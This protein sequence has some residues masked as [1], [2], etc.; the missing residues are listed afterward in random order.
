MVYFIGNDLF[1]E[2]ESCTI[3]EAFDY[4]SNQEV[5]AIDIETSR[6]FKKGTYNETV[7]K[8]G[9]DPFMS[10]IIMFQ[11]GTLEKRFAIDTRCIDIG[12]LLPILSNPKILKV[13]A[14]LIFESLHFMQSY[15][16]EIKN[17]YDVLL[18]D[19][20]LTNGLY[21]SYSLESLMK[22]YRGYKNEGSADLFGD[23]SLESEIN[24]LFKKRKEQLFFLKGS[25]TEEDEEDLYQECVEEIKSTYVDKSIRLEFVEL[26][27]KPFRIEHITYGVTDI[28][29]PLKLREIFMQGR[30]I[31][32]ERYYP[33][34][35]IRQENKLIEVLCKMLHHGVCLDSQKWKEL[36]KTKLEK[37]YQI[38]DFLNDYIVSNHPE[39]CGPLDMFTNKP[40]SL[41]K[42]SSPKQIQELFDKLG[43]TVEA[44]S[45]FTGKIEKTVGAKDLVKSLTN[46]YKTKF[47]EDAIP[48]K[49]ESG[50][51]LVLTYLILK[52]YQML[53]TTYGE[54]FLHYVHPITKRIHCN[55]R[56]YLNTTRFAATRPNALAI[57]RGK[58]YREC[59]I[60]PEGYK[61]WACDYS[62]QEMA[63]MAEMFN[64]DT[65]RTFFVEKLT[66]P[67]IDLHSWT[68]TQVYKI[69]YNDP[70]FVC[71]KKVH[72]KERQASKTLSFGIPYGMGANTLASN[73][74]VSEE[75][76]TQFLVMYFASF[77]GLEESFAETKKL[78]VKRG[79]IQICKQTDKRYFF[80]NFKRMNDAKEVALS[81]Y[82]EDYRYYSPEKKAE[83]KK[84][85][86]ENNPEVKEYWRE[87]AIEKGIL[88]RRSVNFRIQG[89]SA[90]QSKMA[91][92]YFLQN[93][94][95][96]C[97]PILL[98]HD[99]C[100][101][102]VK[103]LPNKDEVERLTE[104][105]K[106]Q[107]INGAKYV[108]RETPMFAEMEYG[109]YWIH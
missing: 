91:L 40:S 23:N 47:M 65:L 15:K 38:V 79:W 24:K 85:L 60:A 30:D 28:E 20:I 87:F 33:E 83:F 88:E 104:W 5:V 69:M 34:I 105:A 75:E 56:Q 74:G 8:P 17:L 45:K 90:T 100:L 31:G 27:D 1:N 55:I 70:N 61:V 54:E 76:A 106:Q 64:N 80:R 36:A 12:P 21:D 99:E 66:N 52:K 41:I 77:P 102:Y 14:N 43:L 3:E 7:Y 29:E 57:P 11:I 98:V 68:A 97:F 51:D 96:D 72:K 37:Y 58:E 101:G 26:G 109:D 94:T 86:Y 49:I 9:L 35:A 48:E 46:E 84:E 10:R 19:R 95:E 32:G 53:T 2:F 82:P 67:N 50:Q 22:R 73:L 16:T 62:T 18:V 4:L 44:K 89:S 6:K 108:C 59:F 78:A 39:Y 63:V 13:G 81:F 42:W 107:M 92:L 25:V 103:D 71:D 93:W